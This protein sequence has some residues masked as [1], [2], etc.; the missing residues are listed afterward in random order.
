MPL[1][2]ADYDP[3]HMNNLI[4]SIEQFMSYIENPGPLRGSTLNVS[5]LPT[6][7]SGLRDGDVFSDDGVLSIAVANRAYAASFAA[8]GA[9]GTVTVLTP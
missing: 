5:N 9:V 8:T 2:P 1:P 3:L 4:R 6:N 7:G